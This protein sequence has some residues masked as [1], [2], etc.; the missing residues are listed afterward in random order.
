MTLILSTPRMWKRPP[1]LTLPLAGGR[2]FERSGP[3]HHAPSPLEGEGWGG[4]AL[5]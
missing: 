5:S 2:E 4:G 1:S 3:H